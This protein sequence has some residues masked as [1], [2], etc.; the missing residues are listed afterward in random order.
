[1]VLMALCLLAGL[2][3]GC[4]NSDAGP[5]A[6]SV[7]EDTLTKVSDELTPD[8]SAL[9]AAAEAEASAAGAADAQDGP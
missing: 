1:M 8:E 6:E 5:R 3:T 2:G 4:T 7:A 9:V